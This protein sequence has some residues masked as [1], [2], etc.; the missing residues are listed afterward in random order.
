MDVYLRREVDTVAIRGK[1]N[2]ITVYEVFD[3]NSRELLEKKRDTE[4]LLKKTIKHYKA[5]EFQEALS[6]VY[7]WL[8]MFPEDI[9]AKEY[10]KR[11]R[12]FVK[13]PP[14]DPNWNSVVADSDHLIDIAIWRQEERFYVNTD[15]EIILDSL[16]EPLKGKLIDISFSGIKLGLHAALALEKIINTNFFLLDYSTSDEKPL[17][18]ELLC[19][20]V[21][22]RP[23]SEEYYELGAEIVKIT[24]EQ[25][26]QLIQVLQ[27]Y[28]TH[29]SLSR[30]N[31]S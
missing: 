23:G 12:Y 11:C 5:K 3:S 22:Q 28:K 4:K 15:V 31:H 17:K 6:S 9:V 27:N 20:S 18:F 2:L 13:Y 16:P 8:D 29:P 7:Q 24:P 19:K 30:E 21:W 25:E 10:L 1:K 14:Q 26:T